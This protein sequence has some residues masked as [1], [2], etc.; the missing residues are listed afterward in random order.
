MEKF[1]P[2][3]LTQ[4]DYWLEISLPLWALQRENEQENKDGSVCGQRVYSV[5]EDEDVSYDS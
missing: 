2:Q 3:I 5:Q 4:E 1:K